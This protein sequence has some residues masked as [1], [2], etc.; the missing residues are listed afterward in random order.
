MST[1][2]KRLGR[3]LAA[4]LGTE[5]GGWE[6]SSLEAADLRH[7][8]V[9]Q[10]DPNPF[11]PRRQFDPAEIAALADSL[12]QHGMLQP[13]LVRPVG[14]RYQL[15]AGERRLRASVEAQ[16]HEV[17]AR[18]MEL[19]DQRVCELAMVENLQREDLNALE[20]ARAFRSYLDT[21]GGTQEELA[22]R[23]GLDRSTVSNLLRLL[24][25]PEE[26]QEAVR[27]KKITQGHARALLGLGDSAAQVAACARV[28][29]ENLSVRQTEALVSTGEPT[30]ARPRIRKDPAHADATPSGGKAPHFIEL[31]AH[32]KDR[33]GTAVLIRPRSKERGQIVI[34]YNSQEEFDRITALIRG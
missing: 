14:D 31:E 19:D 10:I 8:P 9:D 25:L 20:K 4:L 18:I 16:L 13:I 27:S 28:I 11:Q 29:A 26:V 15:I 3:G 6:P 32:L 24:E 1:T 30:P 34:E 2:N 12:R 22:G 7:L 23:L 33:F 17:P 5:E 21:Y